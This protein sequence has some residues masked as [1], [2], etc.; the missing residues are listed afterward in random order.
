MGG[1][2][3]YDVSTIL[4]N[5]YNDALNGSFT[6]IPGNNYNYGFTPNST[7]YVA[8]RDTNNHSNVY[9]FSGTINCPIITP[10]PTSTDVPPTATPTS[11]PVPTATPTST[12]VPTATPTET[13]TPTPTATPDQTPNWLNNGSF[14][15]IGCD[16]HNVEFDYNQYSPTYSQT[17]PGSLV[18]ANSTF[19]GG[20][21][22]QSTAANWVNEGAAYCE[23]CVSKQSQRDTNECSATYNQTRV[24]DSGSACDTSQNWVNSG[25]YGCYETCNKYNIEVLQE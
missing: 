19:C 6:S 2:G 1:S 17:R 12:P 22:G 23:S 5:T 21:C 24:I 25:S 11:T 3:Q 13:P 4:Q 20:C 10:T 14:T 7:Y 15:C 16:K 9:V 8:V 18:E